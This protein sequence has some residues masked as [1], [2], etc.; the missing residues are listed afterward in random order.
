MLAMGASRTSLASAPDAGA[1]DA[2]SAAAPEPLDAET[3]PSPLSAEDAEV[4]ENLELLEHLELLQVE[5]LEML[6][7]L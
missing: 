1:P 7:E 6:L 4:I 3:A 2:E 5:D